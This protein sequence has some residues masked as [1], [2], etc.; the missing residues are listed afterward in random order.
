LKAEEK[1]ARQMV[2]DWLTKEMPTAT[3]PDLHVKLVVLDRDMR[4][5]MEDFEE[6]DLTLNAAILGYT[7]MQSLKLG[8][9]KELDNRQTFRM[10]PS[11]RFARF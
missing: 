5:A 3:V 6:A 2:T 1:I 4:I 11:T 9:L 8:I 7:L 10:F